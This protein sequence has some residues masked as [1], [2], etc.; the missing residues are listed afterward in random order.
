MKN[1]IFSTL[2]FTLSSIIFTANSQNQKFIN[3]TI[4]IKGDPVGIFANT[5]AGLINSSIYDDDCNDYDNYYE[6]C[7]KVNGKRMYFGG[8]FKINFNLNNRFTL[9]SGYRLLSIPFDVY[10]EEII[11]RGFYL[12]P[13]LNLSNDFEDTP[14]VFA[15]FGKTLFNQ[16]SIVAHWQY[17]FGLGYKVEKL[18]L[19]VGYNFFNKPL[20]QQE[21]FIIDNEHDFNT[22]QSFLNKGYAMVRLSADLF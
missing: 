6:N 1:Y 14:F 18:S 21:E 16:E 13:H 9:S 2:L 20:E 22:Q 5:I 17:T 4:S 12:E 11:T 3:S 15:Q 7:N 10:G 19:D 8:E